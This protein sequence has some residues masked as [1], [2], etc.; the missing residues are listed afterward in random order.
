VRAVV[1]TG[2][3]V[4]GLE[5][6]Q[7]PTPEPSS[8]ES[9]VRVLATAI[10]RD[11]L[12]WHTVEPPAVPCH[13]M[14]GVVLSASGAA[15]IA[16]G[17]E[18]YSLI[19]FDRDGAAAEYVSVP[20]DRLALKPRTLGHV[21]SAALPLGGLSAWQGLFDHGRLAPGETVLIHGAG[22][23][24]GAY[25]VQL[26]L[27]HG[28]HVVAVTSKARLE[29]ARR[30]GAHEV[31]DHAD[32]PFEEKVG[33]VDLVFDTSGGDKL[34]RSFDVLAEGGRLISIA[35]RPPLDRAEEKGVEAQ[36][37]IV[38]PNVAQLQRLAEL[39][40]GGQLQP[41]IDRVYPLGEAVTAF[42]RSLSGDAV[43]KVVLNVAGE[44]AG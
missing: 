43:G 34:A 38:E 3:G 5:F 33:P 39:A 35:S 1:D 44:A 6:R 17:D 36:F 4:E 42:R 10:T 18:V 8:G 23:G 7:V 15:N 25:A 31:I 29:S 19:G 22:G 21:E 41:A 28:A 24:V 37:F 9:L 26:A 11:E 20:S 13:E 14:S 32:T 2:S 40:E 16:P 27:A 30:L 12:G